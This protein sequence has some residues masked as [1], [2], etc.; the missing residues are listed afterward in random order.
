MKKTYDA[1]RGWSAAGVLA[2]LLLMG[3]MVRSAQAAT[4]DKPAFRQEELEQ[5]LAPI[6]LYPDNLL[7]QILMA[8]TYP[9]EVVQADRW[10][11]ENKGLKGSA[12]T[13]ALEAKNWD[14]SVKSLVNFSSVLAMMSSNLEVTVKIGD[15]FIGQQ[16]DVMGTIQKLRRMAAA[17][18]NLKTTPQQTIVV[19]KEADTQ[20]IIIQP[21]NP[22]EY[23]IPT[24]SPAVIYGTWPYPA[25]PPVAYYPPGYVPG[26]ALAF[27]AGVAIGA[28]WGYAWGHSNWS[29]GNV[30][31]NV[32]R[33]ANIN[34]NINR[35]RYSAEFQNRNAAFRNG[36]GSF[37]HNP[38]HRQGVAY[39][40]QKTASQFG[41]T[42]S[43]QAS[44][45]REAYRG[46][47]EAGAGAVGVGTRPGAGAGAAG[48][49][50]RP[51]AGASG[52][53][54]GQRPAAQPAAGQRPA[55][56]PAGRQ[57]AF[58]GM[59]RGGS[60][61]RVESQRGQ[62][63]RASFSGGGGGA[64]GGGMGGARGGGGRSGGRR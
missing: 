61:A 43:S 15:A 50:A 26:R 64:R 7:S 4:N 57:N 47:G 10:V 18:G 12:L 48:V 19:Q 60:A 17:S 62:S 3:V 5:M 31:V 8:S 52:G 41:R 16:K 39:R 63:S 33:N 45:A 2:L 28:A 58:E 51:G 40:D 59:D 25:Y 30:D 23:Y 14:A 36:Q 44:Q 24:Y 21:A 53:A 6:A 29:H 42:S 32:N 22:N 35:S 54:A 34:A 56:Q 13:K 27:T 9:L 38:E 11:K 20:V 46:R 37:Q 55:A 49:G 1:I